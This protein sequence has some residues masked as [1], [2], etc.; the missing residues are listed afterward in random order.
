MLL[1][2][3]LTFLFL[4]ENSQYIEYY[5]STTGVAMDSK[6]NKTSETSQSEAR[7]G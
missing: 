7:T 1:Y 2:F 6:I 4:E 3:T 5:L